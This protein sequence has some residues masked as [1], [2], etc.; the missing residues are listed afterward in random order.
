LK[1]LVRANAV[2]QKEDAYSK[3]QAKI[4]RT[5]NLVEM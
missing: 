3:W 2:K 5:G 4:M 1:L